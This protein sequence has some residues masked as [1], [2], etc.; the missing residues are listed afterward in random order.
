MQATPRRG[1]TLIELLVVI[2]IIAVLAAILFPVFV[3]AKENARRAKC[4][5]QLK[6]IQQATLSYTDS[7][8]GYL[9]AYSDR[10]PDCNHPKVVK[11]AVLKYAGNK[12][13]LWEC[14]SDHGY[15]AWDVKHFYTEWETSY[16]FNDRIYAEVEPINKA[17][18]LSGCRYQS[19]LIMQWCI[20]S[21]PTGA[22]KLQNIAY[23]DGHVKPLTATQL[24]KQVPKTKQVWG[25]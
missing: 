8:N 16:W 11:E 1:F 15:E 4:L 19:R 25:Q 10:N 14:P 17:K 13:G 23:G 6:Q 12:D 9:P 2:A 21:H 18:E 7:W 22:T 5:N 3:T 24:I 20:G